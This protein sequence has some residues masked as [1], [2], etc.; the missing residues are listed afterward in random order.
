MIKNS[1]KNGLKSGPKMAQRAKKWS[2]TCPDLKVENSRGSNRAISSFFPSIFI[3]PYK[4]L[5]EQCN[6]AFF[7]HELNV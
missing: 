7:G 1:P 4:V 2:K 3:R 5:V 6:D